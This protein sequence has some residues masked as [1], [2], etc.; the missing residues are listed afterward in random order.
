MIGMNQFE[1]RR[2]FN[3]IEIEEGRQLVNKER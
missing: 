3:S 1:F 2:N